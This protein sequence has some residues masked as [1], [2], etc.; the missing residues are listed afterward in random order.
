MIP[1]RILHLIHKF[2]KNQISSKESQQ[3]MEWLEKDPQNR[4]LFQQ[5][6]QME[7]LLQQSPRTS[8]AELLWK[9]FLK[10][11]GAEI[12]P[13]TVRKLWLKIGQVAAV[14]ALLL[15]GYWTSHLLKDNGKVSHADAIVLRLPSGEEF[16]IDPENSQMIHDPLG[17]LIA[18]QQ[19]RMLIWEALPLLKPIGPVEIWVPFGETLWVELPD[20]SRVHL[21]SGSSFVF[22]NRF[23]KGHRKVKLIGEA[24][25]D[26]Q[27]DPKRPFWVETPAFSVQVL[28]TQFNINAYD[29]IHAQALLVEGHVQIHTD[30]IKAPHV[31]QH[32]GDFIE[33]GINGTQQKRV[34]LEPYLAWQEGLLI[35]TDEPFFRLCKRLERKFGIQISNQNTRLGNARFSGTFATESLEQILQVIQESIPFQ[36]QWEGETIH[37]YNPSQ[38][39]H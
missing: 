34:N 38:T 28:G 19:N 30:S 8:S 25:F 23:A 13:K 36:Y 29:S 16:R 1:N 14:A 6:L 22:K 11:F 24:F 10:K 3:L 12:Y 15:A 20:G 33:V 7:T 31:L 2:A 5:L 9:D 35:F 37:V 27:T 4:G 26:V 21:N 17:R 32:S 18:S 39:H